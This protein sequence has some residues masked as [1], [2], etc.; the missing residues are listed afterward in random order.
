MASIKKSESLG[1]IIPFFTGVRVK[2]NTN[3]PADQKS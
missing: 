1:E 3:A 2:F